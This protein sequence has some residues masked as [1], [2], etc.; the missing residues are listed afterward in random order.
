[1]AKQTAA[2]HAAADAHLA[3]QRMPAHGTG[4][5]LAGLLP[6]TTALTGQIDAIGRIARAQSVEIERIAT[7][8]SHPQGYAAA[9][10]LTQEVPMTGGKLFAVRLSVN[11]TY[12]HYPEFKDF[13]A[14]L[15][16]RGALQSIQLRANR[17]ELTTEIYGV[18]DGV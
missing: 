10:A 4:A 2:E 12:G 15:A 17:F 7:A 8:S 5:P 16:Q 14:R 18:P 13:L 9:S 11:G 3:V 6:I 1:L